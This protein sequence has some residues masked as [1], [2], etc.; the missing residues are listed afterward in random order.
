MSQGNTARTL[1]VV[2]LV[3][4]CS[5]SLVTPVVAAEPSAA[6]AEDTTAADGVGSISH[7]LGAESSFD[8][9]SVNRTESVAQ[10]E[11]ELE[12]RQ[13]RIDDLQANVSA[14]QQQL[15]AETATSD[16][17]GLLSTAV[18]WT[19]RLLMIIGAGALVLAG[20]RTYF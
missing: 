15:E 4:F 20:T 2:A 17:S 9:E 19:K 13:E 6:A 10:L 8:N 18:D 11:A 3:V 1:P 12:A 14:L 16:E 7:T 5:V